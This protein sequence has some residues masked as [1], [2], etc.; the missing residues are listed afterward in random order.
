M[1][2]F[3][4]VTAS[5]GPRLKN[6]KVAEQ[7]LERFLWDGDVEAVIR[8]DPPGRKPYLAICGYDW[9]GA[10]RIPEGVDRDD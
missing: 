6:R 2:T 7:I 1:A 3:I 4:A 9:P 5:N 8:T 10:W